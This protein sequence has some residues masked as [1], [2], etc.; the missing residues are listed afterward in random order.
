VAAN[1][2]VATGEAL[3]ILNEVNSSNPSHLNGYV[4]VAGRRAEVII[5]N[6]AGIQVNGGGFINASGVTLTTGT[7]VMNSGHLDAF[8]VQGGSVKIEGL[9]LDTS[10][11][12]Y[13]TILTRA[14]EVNA[15][16]WAKDLTV[17]TGTNEVKAM[18]SGDSA[19]ATKI[20]GSG[21]EPKPTFM[22][23]TGALGGMY[24]GKIFLVGTEAGV[25]V[26][27]RGAL[28]AQE[29]TWVLQTDG[30]LVNTGKL[31]A[32]GDLSIQT[33]GA[34]GNTG[35][36]GAT[37]A[38]ISSQG[39]VSLNAGTT[40]SNTDNA[41]IAASGSLT[42]N[43][44]GALDNTAGT[45][46]ADGSVQI[47]AAGM[48]NT[49][50]TVLSLQ[51]T[52]EVDT[53]VGAG[54]GAVAG[55]FTNHLGT[56]A[57]SQGA[58]ITSGAL[59]NDQGLIQAGGALVIDTQGQTLINSNASGYASGAVAG[60][61]GVS[62]GVTGGMV[63]GGPVTLTTGALN[64]AA[65]SIG[66]GGPLR[67]TAG[68]TNN[69]GG[70]ILS[71]GTLDVTTQ[72]SLNNVRG[73][74]QSVGN[75]TIDTQG[76]QLDNTAG[77]IASQSALTLK[78]GELLNAAQADQGGLIGSNGALTIQAGAT[79]NGAS[80]S[81]GASAK[82]NIWSAQTASIT[83][84]SLTNAGMLSGADISLDT[85]SAV[86]N[87][88]GASIESSGDLSITTT[89]DLTNAGELTAN[90]R[91]TL[92]ALDI[93]NT[94]TLE[95][96]QH[97]L[98]ATATF[99]NAAEAS[100]NASDSITIAAT[101]LN[102]QGL[103]NA[104]AAVNPAVPSLVHLAATT[105][106]NT[107]AGA[108]FGDQI[109]IAANTLNNRPAAGATT[110]PVIAARKQLDIGVQTLNNEDG[111]L[112]YSGDKMAVAG[113]LDGTLSATGQAQ[114]INNL[115]AQ[116]EAVGDLRIATRTLTNERR[117][118]TVSPVQVSSQ[119]T[120]LSM[121]S[122][123]VNGHNRFF[124]TPIETT[125]NYSPNQFYLVNPANILSDTQ[126]VTPD[127]TV[128]RRVEVTLDPTD[129]VYHA[130]F[131]GYAGNY[132]LRERITVG[133]A[134][135][136]V[137]YAHVRQDGVAN[138]DRVAGASDPTTPYTSNVFD[139][140]RDTLSFSGA[141][142]RCT[143][144]CTMLVVEP[145]YT[146]PLSTIVRATHRNLNVTHEG[147]ELTRTARQT[148][149]EDRLNADAGAAAS[150][151]SGANMRLDIATALTNRNADIQA[152]AVLDMHAGGA[153]VVNEGQTLKR[154]HSFLNTSH[155]WQMGSFE[156]T[157][158]DISEVIGQVG[159]AL[160]GAQQLNITA[161]TLTNTDLARTTALPTSGLGF[162]GVSLPTAS[163]PITVP[164][165]ALFQPASKDKGYVV[166]SDPR[167]TN[168]RQW[169]GSDYMFTALGSDPN[170]LQKRLGDGFYE[171]KLIREQVAQLTGRRF[172]NGYANDEAQFQALMDSG[173]AYA[174][175]WNLIPGVALTAQQIAQ[176]TTDLVWLVERE[177]VL[178]DG[179]KTKAL[180]PQV[181]VRKVAEGDFAASGAL[182]AGNT[183]NLQIAEDLVNADGRIEGGVVVAQAGRDLSNIGGLMQART[184]L[185]AS[186]GRNV[187]ISSPTH[188]T[189]FN[190]AYVNQSRTELAGVGTMKVGNAQGAK[191]NIEVGGNVALQGASVSN[192]G[193]GGS[194]A[195]KVG[196]DVQLQTVTV[197]STDNTEYNAR[198][199][200]R[201]SNSTELGT[202]VQGA[203]SINIQAGNDVTARAASVN[204]GED[205][206][207]KA[208]NSITLEAGRA[209][210]ESESSMYVQRRRLLSKKSTEERRSSASDVALG[211]SF[212]GGNVVMEAGQDIA[213]Q[214]SS[215][216][217]QDLLLL[218]AG[219]DVSITSEQNT[220]SGSFFNETKKSGFSASLMSGISYGK[221]HQNTDQAYSAQTQV[222]SSVGGADVTIQSGRDT[223]V[224]SS[225]IIA[226]QDLT[227]IAGRDA[228]IEA[229][230]DTL[231][232]TNEAYS[233]SSSI[234]FVPGLSGR[235]TAL[236]KIQST[237][238]GTSTSETAVQSLLSAN[239]GSLTV[240][241]GTDSQYQGSGS[242]NVDAQ[243]GTL[244]AHDAVAL[245]GN[246]VTLGTADSRGENEFHAQSKSFTVG[247]QLSGAVGGL[248][249]QLG[250][251]VQT[252]RNTDNE[253]LQA[254]SA[255]KAG[256][257]A[258][259]LAGTA[260]KDL[261]A[262]AGTAAQPGDP[263]AAGFG[264]SVSVGSSKSRQDEQ[265]ST[266][267]QSGTSIQAANIDIQAREG[268][269]KAVGAK[270]Q[271]QDIGLQAAGDIDLQAA[272]NTAELQSTN[273]GSSA[274]LGV[275]FGFGEQ[276]GIS[277]QANA[278]RSKGNGE[279][280]ETTYDNTVVTATNSLTVRS[281]A[282][283]NLRGAEL[284]G[285]TVIADVG[286][287]LNIQTLQ[288]TSRYESDQKTSGVSVSVCVPPICYGNVVT[289]SLS[290]SKEQIDH[291]FQSAK[292][293]SGIAAGSGG[294]DVA[295]AG[296]T[297]LQGAAITSSATPDKNRLTTGSLSYSDLTN[298]QTTRAESESV[299]LGYGGG[300]ALT[301][302]ATNVVGNLLAGEM[303]ERGLP[304]NITQTSTTQSV[305]SPATITVTGGDAQSTENVAALT[306]RDASTANQSLTN[307]LTLQQAQEL[308][309]AQDKAR[310][311][312]IAANYVGA[313]ITNVIGD[314]AQAQGWPDG[315]WQKTALHGVAGLIQAKVAGTDPAKAVVAAMLNEQ[316]LPVLDEYLRSQ[317]IT[318]GDP[319]TKDEY[320][321]LMEAGSALLGSAFD[322]AHIAHTATVNNYLSHAQW[323]E[324]SE[325]LENCK[326]T[327]ECEQVR[328]EYADLSAKQ[329]A[330]MRNACKDISSA[331]CRQHLE[332]AAK[333]SQ[334]QEELVKAGA[335][336]D[337]YL[338]GND[339]NAQARRTAINAL[340]ADIRR[341]CNGD[342]QCAAK[343]Q[344]ALMAVGSAVLDFVP[345]I[346]DVKGFVE[347]E[348][349]FDY[350]L[351]AVGMAG[352]VGD[353]LTKLLKE[354]KALYQ[355]GDVAGSVK[356]LEEAQSMSVAGNMPGV[357]PSASGLINKTKLGEAVT[358]QTDTMEQRLRISDVVANGD[359]QGVKTEALVHD[360][361]TS[362]TGFKVLDG[363]KYGGNKGLDH[364]VQYVDPDTGKTMTMVIDSK[365][366]ARNGTTGLDSQAA[367][368]AEL[369]RGVMQLSDT[370]LA[371]IVPKLNQSP[372]AQAVKDA[373]LDGTLVKAVAYVDKA[374]GQL[375]IVRVKV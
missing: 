292:T 121:P 294:F 261:A 295:V 77:R 108:I 150:I 288:D 235:F 360:V 76:A 177:V 313:V 186:A 361:L 248:I 325:K 283:T 98:T 35:D 258:Y 10:T 64:N 219:R 317:G 94:G 179:S 3:V 102:N 339:L 201:S 196:G 275:T 221:S 17:V 357:T 87:A 296:N 18:A 214:G 78:T 68:Q 39:N 103:V 227:V 285:N 351:V 281:G 42:V 373:I 71:A 304:E 229:A 114:S 194:T 23:D 335:L 67:V 347:A 220:E 349:P 240:I 319:K 55:S 231:S 88:A 297:D 49:R 148:V 211:S 314:V 341:I 146:D 29:G 136:V 343:N 202:S 13:T 307:Q 151:R 346:G 160:S 56:M 79:T 104:N 152:G 5:A 374:T 213:I 84:A 355:A 190:G 30:S 165:N 117:N 81:N 161:K 75:S 139:W 59:N 52:L 60:G 16:L 358:I 66:S 363:T 332:I 372:A 354:G 43:A 157:N 141:Y 344:Q 282:D 46:G 41:E 185:L 181:Y 100:I 338:G 142:G 232:S 353:G 368:S 6:P 309:A 92:S 375:K 323:K 257:D 321:A 170:A 37:S 134:T 174:Q 193:A 265:Q 123:W 223:S 300:S 1:P 336:P 331:A 271:A 334:T 222:G 131:G 93:G 173:V 278:S 243:G 246:S 183:V 252:A 230:T 72:G 276:N 19:Q 268:N 207:V 145:G 340:S 122:W 352:P 253:R 218:D 206:S 267:Q 254:A 250:D 315:S 12:D 215:V 195:I 242:G 241:A 329:D 125:S 327:A 101:T 274:G 328:K 28:I 137:L 191:L 333:G 305:I 106:N 303:G 172:L 21:S 53:V 83:A 200:Q 279:G 126:L 162:L 9:G 342:P 311:N 129:S 318:P 238:E 175:Q 312:Q 105:V 85:T 40:L 203:G 262:T 260:A 167:F 91:L 326:S 110:A 205:L 118:V 4:E 112:I 370:S 143:T 187:T 225:A 45:L 182:L 280:S 57:A 54:A 20:A 289:G 366:L 33:T 69:A 209:V 36:G 109:A 302:I 89:A 99:T 320:K 228:R 234:G 192:A 14:I 97:K 116:I 86:N 291:D 144:N 44:V 293:Q 7:A 61:G 233:K 166:E 58:T 115:S 127:G 119:T 337:A 153:T 369:G 210:S 147:I 306:T 107:G 263:S 132:G 298:T 256:Y 90:Q 74:L 286:G 111:A 15:G 133:S 310:E 120:A 299:S 178:P 244:L 204:A 301:T 330:E 50:G 34:I 168:Y 11:A 164:Y 63:A 198:N 8:R 237:Q 371:A 32:K 247:S 322:A 284:A 73:R 31:Q 51:S 251:T 47:T 135:T 199:Y 266:T 367:G 128:V 189:S 48:D 264:I 364:V 24:A 208:G 290:A 184:E 226:D 249:T 224:R 96:A 80:A 171:Q 255:L 176:L 216:N 212:S 259:K 62:G 38:L 365:Q 22:L 348:T 155:T 188:T 269:L 324:L 113:G 26:N 124:D 65:G 82:S 277:F 27:N 287:D 169:L 154:T 156:W 180:V 70:E 270:L 2:W 95:A 138:P 245:S 272:K 159:G 316:M 197:G 25:G 130:A 359:W 163:A 217:A 236:G 140:Q 345:V 149:V 350:L 362:D 308:K 273:S 239:A 356:K 158:P